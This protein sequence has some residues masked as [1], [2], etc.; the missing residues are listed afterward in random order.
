MNDVIIN[1]PKGAGVFETLYV[2]DLG[3]LM[4][5]VRFQNGT[6]STYNLGIYNPE[7][8]LLTKEIFKP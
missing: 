7:D 2:S 5:K 6:F 4:L 8:N 3:F 1:T